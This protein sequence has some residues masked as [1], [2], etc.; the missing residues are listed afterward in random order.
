MATPFT[1][2]GSLNLPGDASLPAD[3]IPLSASGSFSHQA[4]VVLKLT[5]AGTHSVGMGTLPAAGAKAVLIKV[6]ADAV[7]PVLVKINGSATGKVQLAAGGLLLVSN[8][9]PVLGITALD[10]EYTA[11]ACVRVW[12]LG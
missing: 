12:V 7:A 4:E 11:A 9:T 3:L 6:D 1:I 10:I 8:P 5:G 2:S